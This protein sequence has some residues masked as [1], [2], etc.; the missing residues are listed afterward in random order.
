MNRKTK[1]A[2][3]TL[4]ALAEVTNSKPSDGALT[5]AGKTASRVGAGVSIAVIAVGTKH[6]NDSI[7][8]DAAIWGG[9]SAVVAAAASL[10]RSAIRGATRR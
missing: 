8:K 7:A 6:D 10:T 9:V 1:K 3:R 2:A 5:R 4:L